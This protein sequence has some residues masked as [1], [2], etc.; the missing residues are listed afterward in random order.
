MAGEAAYLWRAGAW[1]VGRID[2]VDVQRYVDWFVFEGGQVALDL[3]QAFCV[4][5]F[6]GDHADSVLLGEIEIVFA[7]DLAAQT[8][9]QDA[10]VFKE[11]FL[12]GA[13]ERRAVGIFAAEI[14]VPQIV[15]SVELN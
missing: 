8:Y 9:L 15:M 11:T 4:E 10:A 7:V 1:G 14:F 12:E 13:A 5:L 3:G 2:R 6:G